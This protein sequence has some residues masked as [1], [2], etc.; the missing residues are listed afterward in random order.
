MNDAASWHSID[1]DDTVYDSKEEEVPL[2]EEG[3]EVQ[4]DEKMLMIMQR[5]IDDEDENF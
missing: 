5:S 1:E 4:L 2:L 3:E